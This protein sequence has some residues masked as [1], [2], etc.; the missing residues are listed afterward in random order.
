LTEVLTSPI[1]V[2]SPHFTLS[3]PTKKMQASKLLPLQTFQ[4]VN[5]GDTSWLNEPFLVAVH[6]GTPLLPD[7]STELILGKMRPR[8]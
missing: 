6:Q 1:N 8:D 4:F 7:K 5:M 3:T 2:P